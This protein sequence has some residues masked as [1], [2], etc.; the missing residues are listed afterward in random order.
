M[1]AY[2]DCKFEALRALG[3]A[4]SVSD[5][6]IQ[7][8]QSLGATANQTN[9]AVLEALLLNGASSPTLIDAWFEALRSSGYAGSR[10]DME[11]EF[12]CVG[13]GLFGPIV[14]PDGSI[15]DPTTLNNIIDPSGSAYIVDPV[16]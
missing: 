12:W 2:S 14:I 11:T 7:W 13:G 3:H 1:P 4:G 15:I 8:A 10:R 16:P 6:L 9:D 5:M